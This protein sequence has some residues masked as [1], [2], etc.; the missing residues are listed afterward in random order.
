MS[1]VNDKLTELQDVLAFFLD[2][3]ITVTV[4]NS[5][6]VK[7]KAEKAKRA[8]LELLAKTMAAAMGETVEAH[9]AMLDTVWG[10]P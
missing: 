4:E 5:A 3:T 1:A 8:A 9:E 2:S 10:F 7:G 6:E